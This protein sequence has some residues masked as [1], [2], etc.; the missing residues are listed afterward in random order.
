VGTPLAGGADLDGAEAVTG[1]PLESVL[2]LPVPEAEPYVQRHRFRYDSVALRGV[3]AHITLLFPFVPPCEI[4]DGTERGVRD[5]LAPFDAFPFALTRLDRFPE[6]ALYLAPEPAEP[7]V[8]LTAALA[9]RFP[10]HL[11]YGGAYS[12]VIPHLTVAQTP[13]VPVGAVSD[14]IGGDLPVECFAQEVWLMVEDDEHRWRA[15]ARFPLVSGA[16]T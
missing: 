7:F 1:A 10:E 12:E 15:H 14:E 8:A 5:A 11:P 13:N 6:G 16:R 3:P 9:N 4:D 2:L